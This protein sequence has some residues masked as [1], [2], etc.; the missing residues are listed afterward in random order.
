VPVRAIRGA[1]QVDVD[2]QG[3]VLK[4]TREL[5]TEVVTANG[6][7]AD[8]IIS[9]L[10]SATRDISS[11]APAAAARQLGMSDVALIC[12]QE[13]HVEGSMPRV[14]RLVAHVE[15]DLPKDKLVNVYLRGTVALRAEVPAL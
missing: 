12:V 11:I 7:V 14:V 2:E 5:V 13:M 9:M 10:F 6:L 1:T 4:L 3:H 8:D 15:T